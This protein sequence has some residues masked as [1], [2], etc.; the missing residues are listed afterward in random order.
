M[1]YEAPLFASQMSVLPAPEQR[2]LPVP[3]APV[4]VES[5]SSRLQLDAQ[6]S[7]LSQ[8][9]ELLTSERDQQVSTLM[10][11]RQLLA[12]IS[13]EH[14]SASSK[15]AQVNVT[16]TQLQLKKQLACCQRSV[17]VAEKVS[18]H[19]GRMAAF[20]SMTDLD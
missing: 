1:S 4:A 10:D 17:Q 7:A 13:S 3:A 6:L 2:S 19:F 18:G 20:W 14:S 9:L 12:R 16:P 15:Q 11:L 8:S 5:G